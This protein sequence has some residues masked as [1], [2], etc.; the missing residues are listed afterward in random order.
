[1]DLATQIRHAV[2]AALASGLRGE[3]AVTLVTFGDGATSKGDFHEALN[4]AAIHR[5]GVVFYCE[6]NQYAIS[7]PLDHQMQVPTVA[8]R[9]VGYGMPGRT[10]D[11]NDLLAVHAAARAAV[12][13]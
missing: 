6:N 5:L 3:S 8:D 10:V 11:G 4:F 12:A 9:A 7:V 1:P 2:V 13:H